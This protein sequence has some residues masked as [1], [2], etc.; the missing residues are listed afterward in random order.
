MTPD[1]GSST[2]HL[3]I[4]RLSLPGTTATETS[5]CPSSLELPEQQVSSTQDFTGLPRRFCRQ[6]LLEHACS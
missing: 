4:S 1:L 6:Q 3:N 5:A 2:V